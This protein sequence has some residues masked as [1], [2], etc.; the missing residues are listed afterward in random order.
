M[1]GVW[2]R[3]QT[4]IVFARSAYSFGWWLMAGAGLF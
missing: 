4:H 3:L 2:R 1:V